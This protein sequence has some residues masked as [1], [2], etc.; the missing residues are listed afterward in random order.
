MEI[1]HVGRYGRKF[2][3]FHVFGVSVDGAFVSFN[4]RLGD[5]FPSRSGFVDRRRI[6]KH[7]H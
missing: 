2:W 3:I 1:C 6:S 7:T 5:F 4:K